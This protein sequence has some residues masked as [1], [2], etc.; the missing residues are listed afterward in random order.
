MKTRPD[1]TTHAEPASAFIKKVWSAL[2]MAC[3][4]SVAFVSRSSAQQ[5]ATLPEVT[6][7]SKSLNVDARVLKVFNRSFS[8]AVS[9]RWY[10]TENKRFLVKHIM[11]D[12]RHNTLFGRRGA[13]IYD[14]GYG[15]EK[16]IPE[17]LRSQVMNLFDDFSVTTAINVRQGGRN[18]WK[19]NLEND[20]NIVVLHA[21]DGMITEQERIDKSSAESLAAFRVQDQSI[22]SL[23]SDL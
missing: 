15:V 17:I 20:K 1:L 12:M 8:G 18:I 23:L 22:E 7:T 4:L 5:P 3:I 6:V 13:F 14:I 9:P 21:Q 11:N 19:I 10:L 2:L 16:D